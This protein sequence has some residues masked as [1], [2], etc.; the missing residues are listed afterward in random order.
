[1]E[2]PEHSKKKI[3]YVC[4]KLRPDTHRRPCCMRVGAAKVLRAFHEEVQTQR[5]EQIEVEET[6]CLGA[7]SKG[8]VVL[9][10]PDNVWYGNVTE[11]DVSEIVREHFINGKPVA[12]LLLAQYSSPSAS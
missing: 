9:V 11:A 8:C 7:C 10:H 2:T 1:M 4:Q 5:C 6:A 3:V 12:R